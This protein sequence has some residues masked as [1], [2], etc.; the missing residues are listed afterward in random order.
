VGDEPLITAG[1]GT[2]VDDLVRRAG[3]ASIS[4]D[5]TTEWPQYSAE[6]VIARAPDVVVMPGPAHG[7]GAVPAAL[8]ETPAVRSD[9]IARV[10]GNLLFRPG[11]RLVDGLEQLARALHPEAFR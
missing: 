7:V 11:P 1:K 2:F 9:R 8:A 5:E 3:G 4:S 10:D 6:T